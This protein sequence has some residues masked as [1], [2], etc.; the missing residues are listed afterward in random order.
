MEI[1]IKDNLADGA[2]WDLGPLYNGPDDPQ[3]DMDMQE[4][5]ARAEKFADDY[6]GRRDFDGE[7]L[8][9]ALQ[10]YEQIHEMGMK[11]L[12][13][14]T[15]LFSEQTQE[16]DRREL[17]HEIRGQWNRIERLL[18]F[19]RVEMRSLPENF[20]S[21]VTGEEELN[22][23]RH[24]FLQQHR[25]QPFT[26]KE[27]EEVKAAEK[28]LAERTALVTRYDEII[29]SITVFLP[30]E[31]RPL[32][33]DEVLALLHRPDPAPR[34]G[35]FDALL[36]AIADQGILLKDILNALVLHLYQDN[37]QR[38]HPFP[39]HRSLL[40]NGIEPEPIE[41][42]MRCV[43]QRYSV[44]QEYFRVK[45]GF[46]GLPRLHYTDLFVPPV[47][48]TTEIPYSD[49]RTVVMESMEA[50]HS[51]FCSAAKEIFE[52][53]HIDAE[54][55]KGKM[56]GAFC[57]SFAPSLSPY[58][59]MNYTGHLRDLMVL[60]HEIG[61]GIHFVLSRN[62]SYLNYA[63]PDLLSETAA[64]FCEMIAMD[65]VLSQGDYPFNRTNLLACHIESIL[66]TVFRQT[67]ITR[68]EQAVHDRSNAHEWSD[69]EICR[70]WM[71]EN[72][73][74]YGKAVAMPHSY[75][76]GWACVPHLFH[77]HFYCY[78]YIF[79]NLMAIRLFEKCRTS[80]GFQDQVIGLF[81]IGGSK[82]PLEI[83]QEMGLAFNEASVWDRSF[84]YVKTLIGSLKNCQE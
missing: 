54:V 40:T 83:F 65:H 48:E 23:Y 53:K 76:W 29:G 31:D 55:R 73:K 39:M 61:H 63:T 19:L 62:Q 16:T 26:L 50:F 70:L 17:L 77:H 13:Y 41:G 12:F 38:G 33:M 30:E 58:I 11:P 57:K 34:A 37:R 66:T 64:T 49:S 35:T 46:L 68:F 4:A 21:D 27:K 10:E 7:T 36:K 80:P 44:A 15:L 71:E 5:H 20:L 9:A 18:M 43:E 79:G 42:L 56:D 47:P 82:G 1:H 74:L 28:D 22:S 60:A 14:A 6:R 32:K 2:R 52:N 3:L 84:N 45:A 69:E 75:R 59:S 24:F 67:V 81:S 72:L 8:H 25:W 78:N 51:V